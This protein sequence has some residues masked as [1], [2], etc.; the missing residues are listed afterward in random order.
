MN[1]W[2]LIIILAGTS[3]L[4]FAQKNKIS[5]FDL[6]QINGLFYQ[7]NTI[8]PFSGTATEEHPKW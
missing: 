3:S 2:I 1:R 5:V 4:S 8:G 7:R 6:D